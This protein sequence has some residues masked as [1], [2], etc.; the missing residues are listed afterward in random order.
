[1]SAI[2]N[3]SPG[4]GALPEAVVKQIREAIG[5][6]P[7]TRISLLGLSHRTPLFGSI[8]E[9]AE[10][11]FRTLLKIPAEYHVLFLQGGSSLQF[12]MI[13]MALLRGRTEPAE[14]LNTGYWSGKAVKEAALEGPVRILWDGEA[15][16]YHR[17]P[18]PTEY[19][20]SP[21]ASYLHYI[22]NETVEG[23]QYNYIP[24]S[25]G[26]TLVCDMSSD[27]LSAPVPVERY[28]LIYAHAQKNLGPSGVT[29]VLIHRDLLARAP[30]GLPAMLDYRTH[31]EHHSNY[32]TPPVFAIYVVLLVTR[33]LLNDIGG[34][35]A[36]RV[37]NREKAAR[38]YRL[39][40]ASGDFY[41]GRAARADRSIMNVSFTLPDAALQ[42][43]FVEEGED[44][45]LYGLQGHRSCGGIRASLY[46]GVT[47]QAV[48]ALCGYM[49]DF[50]RQHATQ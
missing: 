41:R 7:G 1:M 36:M 22:S 43:R 37:I 6:I 48:E 24:D 45:G 38:L 26:A 19:R 21:K 50:H 34:L 4:P 33:W 12:S 29:V 39:L 9:E 40:D 44:A 3:F 13:P 10:A 23:L 2:H 49:E 30:R 8:L 11:N 28:G 17:L 14:Y 32:N 31:C 18:A 42:R 25:G 47:L 20:A 15:H 35:K 16:D 27:F 5:C 46:N